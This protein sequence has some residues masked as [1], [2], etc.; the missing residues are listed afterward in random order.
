MY[1]RVK[2]H[3][4]TRHLY[5][6][7]LIRE[8]VIT[9]ADLTAMTDT[10]VAKYEGILAR[11]KQIAAKKPAKAEL[12]GTTRRGRRIDDSRNRRFGAPY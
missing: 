3:P 1:A 11:A 4:G 8:G 10:V 9:E 2:A 7:H 12:V 5:A 6:Q